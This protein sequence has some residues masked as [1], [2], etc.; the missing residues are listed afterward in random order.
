[1][2]VK[3]SSTISV[4]YKLTPQQYKT[5]FKLTREESLL[6]SK[7][8]SVEKRLAEL[9][10]NLTEEQELATLIHSVECKYDHTTGCA[11]NYTHNPSGW[12]DDFDH[13][14]FLN[15]VSFLMQK[16]GM[17]VDEIRAEYLAD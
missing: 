3:S 15:R 16:Q 5:W 4:P 7:L 1:M 9:S 13:R 14:C 11:W 17:T 6:K 2:P 10:C 8:A 12:S